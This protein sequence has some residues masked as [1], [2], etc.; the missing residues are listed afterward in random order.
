MA[1]GLQ[2]FSNQVRRATL[3]TPVQRATRQAAGKLAARRAA[4]RLALQ[5]AVASQA[6][7]AA[8]PLAKVPASWLETAWTRH[9]AAT[10]LAYA[11]GAGRH[12]RAVKL[13]RKQLHHF[14]KGPVVEKAAIN[15]GHVVQTVDQRVREATRAVGDTPAGTVIPSLITMVTRGVKAVGELAEKRPKL[16]DVV[17]AYNA[18]KGNPKAV[19]RWVRG[20]ADWMPLL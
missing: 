19:Q 14:S 10:T 2:M 17:S 11:A 12:N 18:I 1:F 4:E 16:E 8:K 15:L 3:L 13:T 5:K 20:L 9:H 6:P 7:A